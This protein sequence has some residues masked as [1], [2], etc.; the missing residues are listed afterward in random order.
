MN[1]RRDVSRIA[2]VVLLAILNPAGAVPLLAVDDPAL[3]RNATILNYIADIAPL[4][5][6]SGD[7]TARS[8][9]DI[10][11]WIAFVNADVHPT[12]KPVF[13]NTA[14]LQ[15]AALIARSHDDARSKLRTLYERVDAHPQGRT[16]LA[17]DAHT[18]ADVQA[19]LKAEGLA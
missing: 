19:A 13:G 17:G 8:H 11:R 12:F 5:G 1:T 15:N 3:T 10:D 2:Q 6:L 4:T 16:W 14:Y 18:D 9:A 7:D